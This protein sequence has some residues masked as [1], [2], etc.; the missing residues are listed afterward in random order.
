MAYAHMFYGDYRRSENP[1]A[2]LYDF[3]EHLA[4]LPD[5]SESRKCEHFYLNCRSGFDAEEWYE[6]F[7]QNSP[8][9][10]TSWS[11]LR[12]HF[13]IK[14]LGASTDILLEIPKQ[15]PVTTTQICTATITSR[16][17]NTTTTTAIPTPAN[18]ATPAIYETTTAN[19]ITPAPIPTSTCI[20]T[21]AEDCETVEQIDAKLLRMQEQWAQSRSGPFPERIRDAISIGT[22]SRAHLRRNRSF[23]SL[24]GETRTRDSTHIQ[25]T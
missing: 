6:N 7:E 9:V 16:E 17:T 14:W 11:T 4:T 20:D 8:S 21:A 24:V 18:T 2:F 13:C 3:E 10:I 1:Q 25:T 15:K 19:N 23:V 22:V 5:V 12:K